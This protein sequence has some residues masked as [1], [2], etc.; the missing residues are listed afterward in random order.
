VTVL[1]LLLRYWKLAALAVVVLAALA[2]GEWKGH[3]GGAERQAL[4]DAAATAEAQQRR[5]LEAE[6]EAAR[7]KVTVKVVT[8]TVEVIRTVKVKGDTIVKQVPVYVPSDA[9]DLPGGFRL[10]YDAAARNEPL[11][12]APGD[13]Q[14]EPV[15]AQTVAAG[16]AENFGACHGELAKFRGLW[17]WAVQQSEVIQ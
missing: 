3:K 4:W 15:S 12:D 8:E 6:L 7:A 14:A 2:Y 13:F 9:P 17:D 1:A 11:P 10:L 5:A 16:T